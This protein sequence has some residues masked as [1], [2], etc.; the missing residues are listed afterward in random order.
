[1]GAK[2]EP[3]EVEPGAG[4][5][6]AMSSI[7]VNGQTIK[8][9]NDNGRVRV[10]TENNGGDDGKTVSLHN[11][12]ASKL[13][14]RCR[15]SFVIPTDAKKEVKFNQP[16]V[17]ASQRVGDVDVVIEEINED[18]IEIALRGKNGEKAPAGLVDKAS[19][20]LQSGGKDYEAELA[21]GEPGWDHRNVQKVIRKAQRLQQGPDASRLSIAIPKKA[22]GQGLDGLKLMVR[23]IVNHAV[24]FEFKDLDLR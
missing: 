24:E 23:E 2:F 8:V 12:T 16:T 5:A 9:I 22:R 6:Q 15:A 4:G 13:S 11:V 1:V 10:I 18:S 7:T 17:G 19:I 20:I 14:L 3:E 21:E